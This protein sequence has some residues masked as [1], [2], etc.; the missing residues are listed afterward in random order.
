DS[1]RHLGQLKHA[2]AAPAAQ[3]VVEAP[4]AKPK[5]LGQAATAA[6]VHAAH[7]SAPKHVVRAAPVVAA[8]APAPKVT[9]C[10]A[11]G[12]R[13]H[14]FVEITISR[15]GLNGHAGHQDGRD[16]VPAPAGGC[17]TASAVQAAPAAATPAPAAPAPA[18]AQPVA[19]AAAVAAPPPMPA[20]P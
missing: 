15:N 3:V 5:K 8:P 6:L 13:T 14:P 17:P 20:P 1:G 7:A 16:I 4:K 19:P 18:S 12:S 11:T 10:H 9:I 2:A